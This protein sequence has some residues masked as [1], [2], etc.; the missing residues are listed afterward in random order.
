MLGRFPF[1]DAYFSSF[2][3]RLLSPHWAAKARLP[4]PPPPSPPPPEMPTVPKEEAKGKKEKEEEE[5]WLERGGR[6]SP[7]LDSNGEIALEKQI[8]LSSSSWENQS[9]IR[10]FNLSP[11]FRFCLP[12][13]EGR[14]KNSKRFLFSFRG[15]KFFWYVGK[16][17]KG[18][19][20]R[21]FCPFLLLFFWPLQRE[22]KDVNEGG[23]EEKKGIGKEEEEEE[24]SGGTLAYYCQGSLGKRVGGRGSFSS[25]T[26]C[27]RSS[28]VGREGGFQGEETEAS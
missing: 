11:P 20:P 26:R 27:K 1:P 19:F 22:R 24:E 23:K 28:L 8:T 14:S 6:I 3:I 4:P 21:H 16:R 13:A 17:R 5:R 10:N 25:F 12:S 15:E 18:P 7:P 2:S 9:R